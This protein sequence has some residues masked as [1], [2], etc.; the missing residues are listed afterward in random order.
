MSAGRMVHEIVVWRATDTVNEYGTPTRDWLQIASLRAEVVERSTEE[1]LAGPGATDEARA[2][3]RT[4]VLDGLRTG[5]RVTFQGDDFL[6]R[7]IVPIGRR[8][9]LELRCTRKVADE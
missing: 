9:R 7:E 5:D 1:F 2:V 3:F 4:R 6:I 8:H